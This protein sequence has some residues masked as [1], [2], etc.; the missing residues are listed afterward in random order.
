MVVVVVVAGYLLS[1][2]A[3]SR[4]HVGCG[5]GTVRIDGFVHCLWP[6]DSRLIHAPKHGRAKVALGL[7]IKHSYVAFKKG[8]VTFL[9]R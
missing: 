9:L 1:K 4:W 8:S 5:M 3:M 2:V 7:G 6:T